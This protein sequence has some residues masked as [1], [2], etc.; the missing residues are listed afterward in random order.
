M[1]YL[2]GLIT[3]ESLVVI[4][5]V[6]SYILLLADHHKKQLPPDVLR[7]DLTDSVMLNSSNGQYIGE[8]Q[9]I[10]TINMTIL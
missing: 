4:C 7:E 1:D 5:L 9:H 6:V 8:H 10:F 3:L 2:R